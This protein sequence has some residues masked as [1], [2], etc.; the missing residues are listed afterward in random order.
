MGSRVLQN[1]PSNG[2]NFGHP[3]TWTGEDRE[4]TA[5]KEERDGGG[6]GGGGRRKGEGGEKNDDKLCE[7]AS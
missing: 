5:E 1:A 2:R 3:E 6:G 4:K 7:F